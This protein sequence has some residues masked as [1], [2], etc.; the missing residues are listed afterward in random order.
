M[1]RVRLARPPRRVRSARQAR[2][3]RPRAQRR[4][5]LPP[6]AHHSRLRGARPARPSRSASGRP[7]RPP[8][9]A[10][11]AGRSRRPDRAR[12]GRW[13]RGS[14]RA[15]AAAAAA[16]RAHAHPETESPRAP[17]T[18]PAAPVAPRPAV[19]ALSRLARHWS[20]PHRRRCAA[21]RRTRPVCQSQPESL[22][23]A[24]CSSPAARPAVKRP[25]VRRL[26][27]Q[28]RLAKRPTVLPAAQHRCPQVYLR[29]RSTAALCEPAVE[30][31]RHCGWAGPSRVSTV[32]EATT[33]VALAAA[34]AGAREAR[35]P[36]PRQISMQA[37]HRAS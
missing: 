30:V 8:F 17:Q 5:E 32:C 20:Q 31:A 1:S 36:A 28:Q 12:V 21:A 19:L 2:A 4:A 23:P 13:R 22:R 10:R 9:A 37:R 34:V 16:P 35:R 24:Y 33:R 15:R 14:P 3:S 18:R 26:A 11:A 7:P 29:R 27:V 25:A 6:K